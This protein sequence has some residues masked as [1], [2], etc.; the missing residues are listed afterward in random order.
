VWRKVQRA[1]GSGPAATI[2][3][4]AR[5]AS[6]TLIMAADDDIVRLDHTRELYEHIPRRRLV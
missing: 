2:D 4:L 5:I 3:D 6:R 1:L